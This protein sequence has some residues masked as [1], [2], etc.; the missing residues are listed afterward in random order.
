MWKVSTSIKIIRVEGLDPLDLISLI[1]LGRDSA[2]VLSPY[3]FDKAYELPQQTICRIILKDTKTNLSSSVSFNSKI[4]EEDGVQWLP[5]FKKEN[6][7]FLNSK[8]EEVASPR[9]L[10]LIQTKVTLDVIKEGE[11]KSDAGSVCDEDYMPEIKLCQ[12]FIDKNYVSSFDDTY[13]Q[14]SQEITE[15]HSFGQINIGIMDEINQELV[16]NVKRLTKLLEIERKC[17]ETAV[18]EMENLKS[19]SLVSVIYAF[20]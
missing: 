8:P 5:L 16:N 7:D 18:K 12:S 3:N 6:E 10:I 15:I 14:Q 9:V 1:S 4:F 11:E 2:E 20:S 17:K 19:G 13:E